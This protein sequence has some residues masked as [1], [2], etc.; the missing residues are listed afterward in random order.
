MTFKLTDVACFLPVTLPHSGRKFLRILA[1]TTTVL[2][3]VHDQS[4][5]KK[6]L[7]ELKKV[8]KDS[9]RSARCQSAALRLSGKNGHLI[10]STELPIHPQKIQ[11]V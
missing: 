1:A 9:T 2:L 6:M 4:I 5:H 8:K 11:I 10:H 3:V 7:A